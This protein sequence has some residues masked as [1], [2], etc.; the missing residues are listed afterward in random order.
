MFG[1]SVRYCGYASHFDDVVIHGDLEE[2]KFAAFLCEQDAV[3]AVI[4]LNFDPLT[5][6]Y[7]ALLGQGKRLSKQE[8]TSDPKSWTIQLQTD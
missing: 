8:V 5:I 6:Q 1:K 2:L 4:T 3:K 7:A